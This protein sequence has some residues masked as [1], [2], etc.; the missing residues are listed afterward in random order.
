MSLLK[1]LNA[2]NA[3]PS[4]PVA[5]TRSG[6]ASSGGTSGIGT[7]ELFARPATPPG[8]PSS[9]AGRSSGWPNSV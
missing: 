7:G 9:L 1:R 8:S 5:P 3:T 6:G 2:E 4:A